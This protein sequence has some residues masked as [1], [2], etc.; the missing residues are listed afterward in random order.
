M[1]PRQLAA[2]LWVLPNTLLGLAVA[3]LVF[4]PGGRGEVVDGVLELWG[5]PFELLLQSFT[6]LAGGGAAAMTLGHVV[7][8]TDD[9]ARRVTRAHERVHV[10]QYCA[11]GPFFLPAY[12][13]SSLA[14]ILRRE[15][16]YYANAFEKHA[17]REEHGE[18]A[19]R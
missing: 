19:R 13:L 2:Y 1:H 6:G 16:P 5:T 18:A 17:R 14:C 4:F 10:R 3:P 9:R 7:L 11:F 15:D 12:F 8:A